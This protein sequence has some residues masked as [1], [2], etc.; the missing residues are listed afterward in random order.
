MSDAAVVLVCP[1]A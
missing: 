1:R